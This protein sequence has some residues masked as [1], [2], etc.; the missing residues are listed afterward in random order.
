MPSP[1]HPIP[2]PVPDTPSPIRR[3]AVGELLSGANQ[4]ILV[5]QGQEYHLRLTRANKLILTK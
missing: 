2:A 4:V 1:A 3:I 5:H